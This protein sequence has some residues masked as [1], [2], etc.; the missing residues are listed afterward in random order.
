MRGLTRGKLA[1]A[2]EVNSETLRYYEQRG[3]LPTPPRRASG[4]RVYPPESVERLRFIKGAQ[5]LGFTLEEIKELLALRV[6]EHASK[7]DIR[8][9]TEQKVQQIERKIQALEQMRDALTALVQQCSGEGPL[10]DC[11]ILE[12]MANQAFHQEP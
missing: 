7:G 11:P 10:S 9:R 4:Y 12:A 2:V 1:Q 6:D 5:E 3:L 8:Q